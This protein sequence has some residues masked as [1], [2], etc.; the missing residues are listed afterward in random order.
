MTNVPPPPFKNIW[1]HPIIDITK[2]KK[3]SWVWHSNGNND[4]LHEFKH[5]KHIFLHLFLRGVVCWNHY[6]LCNTMSKWG[7][8][9]VLDI[10]FLCMLKS[11][12]LQM[13]TQSKHIDPHFILYTEVYLVETPKCAFL[14]SKYKVNMTKNLK[15]SSMWSVIPRYY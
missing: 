5:T 14:Y 15:F 12:G 7:R 6:V 2:K 9:M 8:W 1:V 10:I 13:Y 4:K 3:C 11:T